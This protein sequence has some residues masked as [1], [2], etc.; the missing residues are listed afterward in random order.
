MANT[1]SLKVI[2][3]DR[4]F[5]DG[6]CTQVF[7]RCMMARK[8]SRHIMKIWFLQWR[9]VKSVSQ[10]R[11]EKRLRES[12]EPDLPRSST[13]EPRCWWIRANTRRRLTS[14]VRRKQK[15]VPKSSSARSRVFRNTTV[16]S[17]P[18]KSYGASESRQERYAN[19]I[20]I[21]VVNNCNSSA[22]RLNCIKKSLL[23]NAEFFPFFIGTFPQ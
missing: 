17:I 7:C 18:R 13:I 15:S 14:A 16:P 19:R 3:C 12:R 23:K 8:Q 9:S 6:R 2:A 1:F 4:I 20:L 11:T 5:F 10:M 21:N 22:L